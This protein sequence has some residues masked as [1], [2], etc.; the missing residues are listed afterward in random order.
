V[1]VLEAI[2][3]CLLILMTDQ[4]HIWNPMSVEDAAGL[5]SDAGVPWWIAGG[6]AIDLFLGRQTRPHGDTD[7]LILREDQ[8]AVQDHLVTRG[9]ELYKTQQPGLKPWPRGE[10]LEEPVNDVWCRW[11][12]DTPWVLQ[13]MF[14][15]TDRDRW[16]FRRDPAIHGQLE[17]LGRQ[18]ALG[19]PYICPHIQLLYKAKP[20]ILA[21]DQSDFELAVPQMR[22]EDRE[23][24]LRHLERLF[25]HDH[26]WAEQI[27]ELM[28]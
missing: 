2:A 22:P 11:S 10:F 19:I 12:S 14:L 6:W 21:K 23:W 8:L 15:R 24:L 3:I 13:L 17:G 4:T 25:G 26:P 5:M 20:D 9:L 1:G 28:T 16:V 18:T 7:V 27:K